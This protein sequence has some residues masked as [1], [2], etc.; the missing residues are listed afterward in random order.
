MPNLRKVK[1]AIDF[2]G[3]LGYLGSEITHRLLANCLV[4]VVKNFA[5]VLGHSSQ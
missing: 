2:N 3:S 4:N 5:N 1:F